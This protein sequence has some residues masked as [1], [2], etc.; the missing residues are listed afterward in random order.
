[1]KNKMI[2]KR[3]STKRYSR[4]KRSNCNRKYSR[5]SCRRRSKGKKKCSWIK[6]KSIGRYRHRGYCKQIGGSG[7]RPM[8]QDMWEMS[9]LG[10]N[11]NGIFGCN[12]IY[13][14]FDLDDIDFN[15][16]DSNAKFKYGEPLAR[17]NI[18][19]FTVTGIGD[20]NPSF[21]FVLDD[22]DINRDLFNGLVYV[23]ITVNPPMSFIFMSQ[24]MEEMK[25]EYWWGRQYVWDEKIPFNLYLRVTGD[26]IF[27][28]SF[29]GIEWNDFFKKNIYDTTTLH[30]VNFYPFFILRP[31]T[32]IEDHT[33]IDIG[34]P[35][36]SANK[37]KTFDS[38]STIISSILPE[39][40]V[41]H[42]PI[43]SRESNN[44]E[45][46]NSNMDTVRTGKYRRSEN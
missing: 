20:I 2:G 46:D 40:S 15:P 1:M 45:Y 3:Y 18:W 12:D 26:N 4:K 9:D 27:Q 36:K 11:K 21:G 43:M 29:D 33:I 39:P 7:E 14:N 6:K 32:K 8:R 37:R 44:F 24:F 22:Y 5:R 25:N 28:L 17:N 38:G 16:P 34:K 30:G 13:E 10:I 42:T 23:D 35:T 31:G 19:K 41:L